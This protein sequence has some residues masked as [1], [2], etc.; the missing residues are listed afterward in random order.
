MPNDWFT[1]ATDTTAV[2]EPENDWFA[3]AIKPP[4]EVLPAAET[5]FGGGGAAGGL[6]RRA[7]DAA[8]LADIGEFVKSVPRGAASTLGQQIEGA[9]LMVE[10]VPSAVGDAANLISKYTRTG[11]VLAGQGISPENID[12]DIAALATKTYQRMTEKQAAALQAGGQAVQQGAEAILPVTPGMEQSVGR[13][14][15]EALGSGFAGIGTALV[16]GVPGMVLGGAAAGYTS[17]YKEAKAI[18]KAAGKPEEEAEK[19]ARM[20]ARLSGLVTGITE[21]LGPDRAALSLL[22][23]ANKA[24]AGWVAK[25]IGAAGGENLIQEIGQEMPNEAAR[26]FYD[27]DRSLWDSALALGQAG[28]LGGTVGALLGGIVTAPAMYRSIQRGRE[29]VQTDPGLTAV[30]ATPEEAAAVMAE[31]GD[32]PTTTENLDA[33]RTAPGPQRQDAVETGGQD[34]VQ[35]QEVQAAAQAQET[36]EAQGAAVLG[37][38]IAD[39]ARIRPGA[40]ETPADT[41]GLSARPDLGT[42]PNPVDQVPVKPTPAAPK[43]TEPANPP[44]AEGAASESIFSLKNA[45][46]DQQR[47]ARGLPPLMTTGRMSNPAAWDAAMQRLEANPALGDELVEALSKKPRAVDAVEEM[48]VLRHIIDLHHRLDDAI[49]ESVAAFDSGDQAQALATEEENRL[50]QEKL[51]RAEEVDRRFG[52]ITGQALQ[53]RKVMARED[54]S[55][56]SMVMRSREAKGGQQLTP[57]EQGRITKQNQR[58]E[59]LEARIAELEAEREQTTA[60]P[61]RETPRDRRVRTE[62]AKTNLDAVWADVLKSHKLFQNPLDPE[63][64]ADGVR[65]AKAYI[66]LGVAKFA[67][68]YQAVAQKVGR[69][70]AA[71]AKATLEAAWEEAAKENRSLKGRKTR[72][73]NEIADLQGRIENKDFTPKPP[74]R[75]GVIDKELDTLT[76]ERNNVKAEYQRTLEADRRARMHI[77]GKAW[78]KVWLGANLQKEIVGSLD[79]SA[80]GRHGFIPLV[81]NPTKIIPAVRDAA[82][83]TRSEV[84]LR[85]AT[86]EI[87][88]RLNF[89]LYQRFGLELTSLDGSLSQREQEY[90][91][92]LSGKIPG[93]AA[94][95]RAYIA[96]LNRV[97]A[98][99]MDTMLATHPENEVSDETGRALARYVNEATMRGGL[100]RFTQASN[101]LNAVFWTPRGVISRFQWLTLHPLWRGTAQSRRIIAKQYAKTIMGVATIFATTIAA[102]WQYLGPPSDDDEG[103]NV[104]T[105]PTSSDFLKIRIGKQRIDFLAGLQQVVVLGG[106][107]ATGHRTNLDGREQ[108][109]G[110]FSAAADFAEKKLA[111]G[112]AAVANTAALVREK[113]GGKKAKGVTGQPLTPGGIAAD[114][115]FP[116]TPKNVAEELRDAGVPEAVTTFF[117]GLLGVSAN[118]Y[119][120]NKPVLRIGD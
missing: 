77:A 30:P 5:D 92:G 53:A 19:E 104:E 118:T 54:Y 33:D 29:N 97:R 79:W 40:L 46:I 50:L 56:T 109:V 3:T 20:F 49:R 90:A 70:R 107:L 60:K 74:R 101:E 35:A 87:S 100:G 39:T 105:N 57:A 80:L 114:A 75:R 78:N 120:D 44:T 110:G 93:V 41:S 73:R 25:K 8:P 63:V 112:A 55:L 13:Q 88:E 103:W 21:P 38:D 84:G 45:V 81:A 14:V 2:K 117:L 42:A 6:F 68:F 96:T 108:P 43:P 7:A 26:R 102:L 15:G 89:P 32:Q 99:L 76:V 61:K 47:E 52:T 48:V 11:R 69:E 24:T 12:P 17:T 65:L 94:S 18:A 106:R 85:R 64:L 59:E 116:M 9:G 111:P 23:R 66:D 16:G 82:L 10:D 71:K 36:G 115:V 119:E 51:S 113:L 83:A 34:E 22:G 4:E 58:L 86:R 67:D 27:A 28:L 91:S 62:K 95:A 31:F 37:A 1:S 98:D 72:L